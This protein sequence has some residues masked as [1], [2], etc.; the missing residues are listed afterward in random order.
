MDLVGKR[1]P[2]TA[3][4]EQANGIARSI[5]RPDQRT[6][7]TAAAEIAANAP[8]RDLVPKVG[9]PTVAEVDPD[10]R[11]AI[12][13]P[14]H[15]QLCRPP[16]FAHQQTLL[17]RPWLAA[18]LKVA[19][20]AARAIDKIAPYSSVPG[21]AGRAVDE[22]RSAIE[23]DVHKF[24]K[25]RDPIS[26]VLTAIRGPGLQYRVTDIACVGVRKHM[27]VAQQQYP[28]PARAAPPTS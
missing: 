18:D 8:D 26:W 5:P 2:A 19:P 6:G 10:T 1:V 14:P 3:R 13:D 4:K 22:V 20:L 15:G 21:P 23:A 11:V 27:I 28:V 17:A 7:I 24:F 12:R 9:D 16:A 25:D